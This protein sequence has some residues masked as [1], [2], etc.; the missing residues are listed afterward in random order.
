MAEPKTEITRY[1]IKFTDT[2][3]DKAVFTRVHSGNLIVADSGKAAALTPDQ[4]RE[5]ID[6]LERFNTD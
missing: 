2:D 5:L 1:S 4:V 6:W 3:G